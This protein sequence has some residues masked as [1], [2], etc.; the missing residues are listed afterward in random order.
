VKAVIFLGP[1]LPVPEAKE[2]LDAIY[3]P[4]A[5]QTDFLT[6]TVNLRPDVIG[7]IDGVFLHSLSVWH[8]EI[9]Y[10]LNRGV[11]VFGASSMGALR[12]AETAEFGM[13]G[14]GEIYRQYASGELQDDDEVALAHASADQD[15]LKVSEPMVNIRATF[16]AAERAG[17]IEGSLRSRLNRI[18]KAMYFSD[19]TFQAILKAAEGDG[20]PP[21]RRE[22]LARFVK[23]NYVDQKRLDAIELLQAVKRLETLDRDS[24]PRPK[25]F[26]FIRSSLFGTLYTRDR[27]VEH[28]PIN[29]ALESIGNY[30]SLHDT[31][32]D[33]LNFNAL[34]RAVVFEFA[35]VLGIKVR[36]EDVDTE[37]KRFRKKKGLVTEEDLA[38]WLQA[39][40]LSDREFRDLM[41]QVAHCRGLHRWFMLAMWMDRTTQTVLDELRLTGKYVDWVA[42]AAAQER[43][44]EKR[45]ESEQAWAAGI[46]LEDV[47][48][49]HEQWTGCGIDIDPEAWAEEAGYHSL[50]NLKMELS[51]AG[52]ARRA[53]LELL[54]DSVPGEEDVNRLSANGNA[55]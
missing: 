36:D 26:E 46:P 53:L 13:I 25:P 15:Y 49:E 43:L 42:R 1:S 44:L 45:A 2:I 50:S 22:A 20:V 32:F 19:R 35:G 12:A 30:V 24:W 5:R 21:D 31:G 52:A 39:N 16:A 27:R 28:G 34:N 10:A 7:L 33:E 3:L 23:T 9:L 38:A 55:A 11:L 37:S 14:V 47:L 6:A 29:L 18:A 4:P 41:S 48:A 40:H 17:I 51:R 54:A 8:K